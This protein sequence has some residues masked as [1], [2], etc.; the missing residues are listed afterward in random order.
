MGCKSPPSMHKFWACETAPA[1]PLY[2]HRAHY[3]VA[4]FR[5]INPS[6]VRYI[7]ADILLGGDVTEVDAGNP[8]RGEAASHMPQ[9][10]IAAVRS[11]RI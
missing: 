10:V 3:R 4:R 9:L 8:T 1:R 5:N 6:A 2:W 11:L 7:F